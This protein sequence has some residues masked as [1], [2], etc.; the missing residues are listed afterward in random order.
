MRTGELKKLDEKIVAVRKLEGMIT[1]CVYASLILA[2]LYFTIT[3]GWPK[4]ILAVTLC[5]AVA[6]VPFELY[7]LPRWKYHLWRYSL[8]EVS[9]QIHKGIIFR[10]KVLIPMGKVQHVEAKQGPILKK[11]NL[12]TVTLSTAAGSHDIL[13]LAEGTADSIRKDIEAY[14]RLSDEQV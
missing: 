10:R 4:W 5:L 3:F 8:S 14:A 11:Y 6:S 9:I 12:Y 1:L 2:L 7:L 13:G